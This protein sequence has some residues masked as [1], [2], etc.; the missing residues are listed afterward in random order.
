MKL[1]VKDLSSK[2]LEL[3]IDPAATTIAQLKTMIEQHDGSMPADRAKLIHKGKVLKDEDT[4]E[5]TG[6]TETEFFVC[7][8]SKPKAPA[9][10][11]A[12]APAPAP[13]TAAAPAPA[14]APASAPAPAPAPAVD[15][16]QVAQL[17]ELGFTEANVRAALQATGGSPDAAYALL[18][19][20]APIHVPAPSSSLSGAAPASR[21]PGSITTLE[22]FRAHP[23]FNNLRRQVQSNPNQLDQVLQLIGQ[24]SPQLLQVILERQD[25][26]IAM[27]NEPIEEGA[28]PATG[29]ATSAV[30]G[31]GMGLDAL[32]GLEGMDG[33]GPSPQQLA[34][35]LQAMPEPQRNQLL[36]A[37]TGLPLE[38]VGAFSQQL[39]QALASGAAPGG[40]PMGGMPP[41]GPRIQLTEEEA[42]NLNQLVEMGFDRTEAL[43]VFLAC[44][45]NVEVA[46]SILFDNMAEDRQRGGPGGNPGGNAGDDADDQM[47]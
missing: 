12:P 17:M 30:A 44:G 14:P 47:Y 8:V 22:E 38:Q 42:A 37:L 45:K 29:D 46:A 21:A 18:E 35:M 19:S 25:E 41:A 9:R 2:K 20:G 15:E 34:Q 5:S 4:V 6:V 28:A 27:M 40:M 11:P 1:Q 10:A 32:G 16:A 26:F 13:S 23:Q 31:A 36:G 3:E 7:M 24:Q 39:I 43:Q 33:Q